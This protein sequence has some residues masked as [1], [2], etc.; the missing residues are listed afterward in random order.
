MHHLRLH[1]CI[2]NRQNRAVSAGH[3]SVGH[4]ATQMLTMRLPAPNALTFL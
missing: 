1:I 3:I 4:S 2:L